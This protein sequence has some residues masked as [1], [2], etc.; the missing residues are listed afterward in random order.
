MARCVGS[1]AKWIVA[2]CRTGLPWLSLG[3][4]VALPGGHFS[5]SRLLAMTAVPTM[6]EGRSRGAGG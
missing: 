4:V 5:F 6:K 2:V 3:L 1:R